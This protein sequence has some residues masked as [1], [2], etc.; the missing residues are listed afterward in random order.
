MVIAV[1]LSGAAGWLAVWLADVFTRGTDYLRTERIVTGNSGKKYTVGG[2]IERV[3]EKSE[4]AV[5]EGKD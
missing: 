3:I 4:E 1:V 2:A 5:E